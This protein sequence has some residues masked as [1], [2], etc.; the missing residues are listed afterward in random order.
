M[1]NPVGSRWE[2]EALGELMQYLLGLDFC[3]GCKRVTD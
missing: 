3:T 1:D 2:K